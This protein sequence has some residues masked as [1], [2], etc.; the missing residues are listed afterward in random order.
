MNQNVLK[1][2]YLNRIIYVKNCFY[3]TFITCNVDVKLEDTRSSLSLLLEF[4]HYFR[5]I[6]DLD[7]SSSFQ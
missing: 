5:N 1:I 2:K 3:D 4:L 6:T 7:R